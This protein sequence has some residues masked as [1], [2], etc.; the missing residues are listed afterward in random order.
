MTL[1]VRAFRS[2]CRTRTRPANVRR[3][4]FDRRRRAHRAQ[5]DPRLRKTTDVGE[6]RREGFGLRGAYASEARAP[7]EKKD[8]Q[9]IIHSSVAA[10]TGIGGD[11]SGA[12]ARTS[13]AANTF[14]VTADASPGDTNASLQS[15]ASLQSQEGSEEQRRVDAACARGGVKPAPSA[16]VLAAFTRHEGLRPEGRRGARRQVRRELQSRKPPNG[17]SLRTARGSVQS[18]APEACA[19]SE[20]EARVASRGPR[21]F[22]NDAA[23]AL[24]ALAEGGESGDALAEKAKAAAAVNGDA[25]STSLQSQK[26]TRFPRRRAIPGPATSSTSSVDFFGLEGLATGAVTGAS[27][28]PVP[29]PALV[30]VPA[31]APAVDDLLG[32]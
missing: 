31:A 14:L 21:V 17:G 29:V 19:R 3:L 27:V 1:L 2:L 4:A 12:F 15:D 11:A 9:K 18:R 6:E 22:G 28:P 13:T 10:G 20:G 5:Q 8:D 7:S 24:R 16:E 25:A 23:D 32:D 30:P 26:G